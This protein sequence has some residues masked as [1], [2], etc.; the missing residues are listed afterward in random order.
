[1]QVREGI[2]HATDQLKKLQKSTDNEEKK[3]ILLIEIFNAILGFNLDLLQLS[4][5]I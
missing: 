2:K 3:V 5:L 4:W 1:M